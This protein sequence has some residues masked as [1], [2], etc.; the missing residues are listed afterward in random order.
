MGL[1]ACAGGRQ[2]APR[3]YQNGH[4]PTGMPAAVYPL[5]APLRG[6][7]RVWSDGASPDEAGASAHLLIGFEVENP[8]GPELV[9]EPADV[10][11]RTLVSDSQ[12]GEQARQR[13]EPGAAR[14]QPGSTARLGLV[15]ELPAGMPP[16]TV[17]GFEVHWLVRAEGGGSYAQVTPFSVYLPA[18]ATRYAWADPWPWWGFGFGY[19]GYRCR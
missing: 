14:A 6:E 16:R 18:A 3:E 17:E 12:V 8:D 7:V 5:P 19:Y 9:L 4:A 15:F 1:C 10:H 11:V 2:F 13:D